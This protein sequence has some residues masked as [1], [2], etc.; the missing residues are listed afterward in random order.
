MS[1]DVV[2]HISVT[3]YNDLTTKILKVFIDG[4]YI[5][6][7]AKILNPIPLSSSL[8]LSLLT[9]NVYFR[10]I[11]LWNVNIKPYPAM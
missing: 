4:T 1:P 8:S 9:S 10:F 2:H 5:F 11:R 7:S 3:Y 6:N